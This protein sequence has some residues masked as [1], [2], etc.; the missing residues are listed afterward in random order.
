MRYWCTQILR[1]W[2]WV[3][4]WHT[5][6]GDMLETSRRSTFLLSP[7][8]ILF[9][10]ASFI[11]RLIM[12]L[13]HWDSIYRMNR[14]ERRWATRLPYF[15]VKSRETFDEWSEWRDHRSYSRRLFAAAYNVFTEQWLHTAHSQYGLRKCCDKWQRVK[16]VTCVLPSRYYFG[17]GVFPSARKKESLT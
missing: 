13:W 11:I 10:S 12:L 1:E 16:D 3:C 17:I 4:V 6:I 9:S 2:N 15:S 7:R 8:A 14:S 5:I